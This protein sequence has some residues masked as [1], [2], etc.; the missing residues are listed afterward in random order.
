VGI[1]GQTSHIFGRDVAEKQF[2]NTIVNFDAAIS[3][4]LTDVQIEIIR[5]SEQIKHSSGSTKQGNAPAKALQDRAENILLALGIPQETVNGL[6]LNFAKDFSGGTKAV[7]DLLDQQRAI[8]DFVDDLRGT[9]VEVTEADKALR[10]IRDAFTAIQVGAPA[11]GIVVDDLAT[12]KQSALHRLATG[13]N[14]L[15]STDILKIR[16]PFAV[17]LREE[18]KGATERLAAAI[19]LGGDLVAVEELNGL[20]RKQ[21]LEEQ[22]KPILDFLNSLNV[23]TTGQS[24]VAALGASQSR[25]DQVLAGF[26]ASTGEFTAQDVSTAGQTFLSLSE[27]FLGG[28]AVAAARSQII[29]QLQSVLLSLPGTAADTGQA[30]AGLTTETARGNAANEQLLITLV[31]EVAGLRADNAA[32]TAQMQRIA[33]Q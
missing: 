1:G 27:Q 31:D 2:L 25:F 16:N 5:V 29:D 20:R 21:I 10:S 23:S 24:P 7:Q 19:K 30:I 4:H 15:I 26:R 9:K 17:L 18:A 12:L 14:D 33:N 3:Q 8:K 11:V 32:L 22:S 6:G 28:P 13:F